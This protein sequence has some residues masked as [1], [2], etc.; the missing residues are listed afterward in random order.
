MKILATLDLAAALDQMNSAAD[1]GLIFEAGT[2]LGPEDP[3]ITKIVSGA[4]YL[5]VL[6]RAVLDELGGPG[7]LEARVEDFLR[8]SEHKVRREVK[9]LAKYVDVRSYVTRARVGGEDA[10]RAVRRAGLVGDFTVLEVDVKI[11]G[12][13]GVKTVEIVEAITG[14]ANVPHRSI[15][16]RLYSERAGIEV[17]PMDLAALRRA[18]L[19]EAPPE[20]CLVSVTS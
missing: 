3:G 14:N 17:D 9:G 19:E 5:V 18:K 13:G 16:D 12:S 15:R 1:E 8:A 7:W 10:R 11:L 20:E 4:R 2:R 6:A